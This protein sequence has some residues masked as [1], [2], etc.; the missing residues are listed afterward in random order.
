MVQTQPRN[1]MYLK[2]LW[3]NPTYSIFSS[4]SQPYVDFPDVDFWSEN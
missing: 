3:K 4:Q 2:S 1:S